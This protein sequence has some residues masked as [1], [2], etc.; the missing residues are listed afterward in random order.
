MILALTIVVALP[1]TR[2]NT[3]SQMSGAALFF[4]LYRLLSGR[5]AP[6]LGGVRSA[7]LIGLV[8]AAAC[9]LRQNYMLPVG[10]LVALWCGAL[11]VKARGRDKVRVLRQTLIIAG[12]SLAFLVPWMVLSYRSNGT[13]LF[14]LM[15]GDFTAG[16]GLLRSSIPRSPRGSFS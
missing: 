1:N 4:A 5:Y 7:V 14:P 16:F 12:A 2:S 10:L 3:T 11:F 6:A 13:F 8:G 9:T 15:K